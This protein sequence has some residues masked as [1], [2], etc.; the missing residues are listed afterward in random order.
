MSL[1]TRLDS[2]DASGLRILT[3]TTLQQAGLTSI[4]FGLPILAPFWRESLHLSLAQVGLLL[5]AFDLGALVLLIPLGALADRWGEPSVLAAGALFTAVTTAAVT[6][7]RGLGALAFLLA[8]AG[9][10]YGSGQTA[11]S[12]AVAMAFG[13][14]SRGTAMGVRQSG[15]PLGGLIAALLLP[16]VAVAFGWR[17]AIATAAVVCAI[18]GVLCWVAL[19]NGGGPPASPGQAFLPRISGI[20]RDEGIRR[21]TGVAMLL[22]VAQFCYQGYLAL[23]LADRF[24]WRKDVAA[25]FLVAVHLGGILGRLGWGAVSD[26]RY[27][28]RRTPVLTWCAG[29]GAAFPLALIALPAP[30]PALLVAVVAFLGGVV[31]LGW[32]GLYTNLIIELAGP[33]RA[34]TAVGVSMTLL[35]ATTVVTPAL[36]GWLVD[37]TSYSVGWAALAGVMV[38][39]FFGTRGI[40]EPV[41]DRA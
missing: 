35:F 31:L 26:V 14:A 39:V 9:L 37:H 16:P 15:L 27:Q 18:P 6:Q 13:P 10:G 8:V 32:N 22:V 34:A 2:Q 23:Y 29:A 28:G 11:G 25:G 19:R 12:K 3:L 38:A 24:G 1:R 21:T 40:P 33:P 4:R 5:G 30:A 7:A 17:A 36:F 41:S 20:L